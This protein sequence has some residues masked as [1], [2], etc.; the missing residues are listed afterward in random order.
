[1][2]NLMCK[3]NE[4]QLVKVFSIPEMRETEITEVGVRVTRNRV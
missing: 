2:L 4:V 1:M 3:G